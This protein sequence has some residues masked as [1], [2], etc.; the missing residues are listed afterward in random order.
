MT[1][2]DFLD[3][4]KECQ[5]EGLSE[6]DLLEAEIYLHDG[7]DGGEYEVE[8]ELDEDGNICFSADIAGLDESDEFVGYGD[9]EPPLIQERP[10]DFKINVFDPDAS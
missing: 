6:E 8:A 2:R 4:L 3:Y 10:E 1:L 5:N 7:F 9:E